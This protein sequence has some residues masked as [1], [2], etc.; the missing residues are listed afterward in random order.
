M[1]FG[2]SLSKDEEDIII[3]RDFEKPRDRA[4]ICRFITE[5]ELAKMDLVLIFEEFGEGDK[6]G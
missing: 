6:N 5:L 2:I 1:K 3:Y 4:E